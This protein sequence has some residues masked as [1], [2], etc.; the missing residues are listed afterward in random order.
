MAVHLQ[1]G[2]ELAV[3]RKAD[4]RTLAQL[5]DAVRRRGCDPATLEVYDDENGVWVRVDPIPYLRAVGRPGV[6]RVRA[7][8]AYPQLVT[9]RLVPPVDTH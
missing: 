1:C 9:P 8:A 2:S 4:V 6:L 7:D 3:P 5:R